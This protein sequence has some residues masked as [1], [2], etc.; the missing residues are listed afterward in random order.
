VLRREDQF[1]HRVIGF[2]NLRQHPGGQFSSQLPLAS[3]AHGHLGMAVD[4]LTTVIQ[5]YG[6]TRLPQQQ[7]ILSKEARKQHA[8]P[9]L[10]SHFPH[11]P[12]QFLGVVA[13]LGIAQ[14][15]TVSTKTA[16]QSTLCFSKVIRHL[17][18]AYRKLGQSGA[19]C[20]LGDIAGGLYGVF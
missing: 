12:A 9:V 7:T 8:V 17:G 11:Q 3:C 15:A 10:I 5:G 20:E 16:T 2:K 18:L 13:V 4:H 14:A 19:G 1:E 6:R